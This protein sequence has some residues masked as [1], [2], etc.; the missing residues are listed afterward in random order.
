MRAR[1]GSLRVVHDSIQADHLHVILEADDHTALS[2]GMRSFAIRIA[3]RVNR[4][5]A[6]ERGHVWGDR[7]HRR[8]LTTPS[9]VRNALVYVLSNHIKHGETDVGLID[10]PAPP[11]HGSRAGSTASSHRHPT[12][13]S[14]G[15][16]PPGSSARAGRLRASS[17]VAKSRRTSAHHADPTAPRTPVAPS[18]LRPSRPSTTPEARSDVPRY[19]RCVIRPSSFA[20]LLAFVAVACEPAP[21]IKTA[22]GERIGGVSYEE[23]FPLSNDG[24]ET[25]LHGDKLRKAVDMMDRA[26]V[27]ALTGNYEATGVLDK[28]TLVVTVTTS[29][30]HE[31]KLVMKNC[32]EPH[33]C[34]FFTE[35]MKSGL[36]D[37]LPVVCRDALPCTKK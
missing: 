5:L 33:V 21:P 28:S 8:D 26:G 37:R 2:N 12:P 9:E 22:S 20:A 16:Q 13:A 17:T 14:P 3:L 11:A 27:I 29:D 7:H 24:H 6:R 4:L 25:T 1:G 36:V 10:P 15:D 30:N 19:P 23:R 32:A 31:R 34:A 18:P 35:A